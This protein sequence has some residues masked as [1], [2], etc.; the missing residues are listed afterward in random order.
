LSGVPTHIERFAHNGATLIDEVLGD[1]AAPHLMLLHG[2]GSSRDSLRGIGV[3]FQHTHCVH[4]VELPGFGEAPPPPPDWDTIHYT[5]LVQQYVLDRLASGVVIVGHSFGGRVSVRL[6]ARRLAP[7]RGLVLMGVPG[8]PTPAFSRVWI[9]RRGIRWLRQLVIALKPVLGERPIQWHTARFGSKDYLAAGALRSVLV[10][11]VNEDL[12]E[13]A[14]S[15]ACPVL[16]IWGSDDTETPPSLAYRYQQLLG[17]RA[18]LEILPHKDHYLY[19][20]TGA[21]LCGEK[22]RTWLKARADV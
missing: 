4:L 7:V 8:L 11:V 19:T 9:R 6:G 12:T 15:I 17:E 22:I 3:L 10:K 2:W 20:G 13:S 18:T 1:P 5:D 14:Q 21:H 16:L